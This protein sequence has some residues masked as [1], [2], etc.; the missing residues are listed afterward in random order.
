MNTRELSRPAALDLEVNKAQEG[1][2]TAGPYRTLFLFCAAGYLPPGTQDTSN[3]LC[4]NLIGLH[5]SKEPLL[6]GP[7]TLS[8]R[9]Q[10]AFA[11]GASRGGGGYVQE[12]GATL[13]RASRGAAVA[14]IGIS[15]EHAKYERLVV[16]NS[17]P[18]PDGDTPAAARKLLSSK[19]C[20]CATRVRAGSALQC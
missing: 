13:T 2:G 17:I 14:L 5:T 20:G 10:P 16:R 6:T 12:L 7:R 8:T 18:E 15:S 11:K 1:R 4:A 9:A 19:R 3:P